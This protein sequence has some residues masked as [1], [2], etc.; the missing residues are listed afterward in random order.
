LVRSSTVRI[1]TLFAVIEPGITPRPWRRAG[2]EWRLATPRGTVRVQAQ[3]LQLRVS[4]AQR[5]IQLDLETGHGAIDRT[6]PR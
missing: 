1:L 5:A 2:I 6:T 4:D 3:D